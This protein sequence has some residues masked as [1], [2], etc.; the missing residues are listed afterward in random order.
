MKIVLSLMLTGIALLATQSHSATFFADNFEASGAAGA[1]RL[2]AP[3]QMNKEVFTSTGAYVGGYYPG[4]TFGPNS[5]VTNQGGL[6]QG[7]YQGKLHPDFDGFGGDWTENKIVKTSLL[8][9]K[10]LTAAD[11]APGVIQMDFNFKTPNIGASGSVVAFAK[12]LN[13]TFSETW[14]TQTINLNSANWASGATV[15]TFDGTQVGANAQFGFT[16]TSQNYHA[17]DLFIDN[18]TISNVPEPSS[19]TLMGLGVAGLLAFRLR[20]KV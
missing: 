10:T 15:L 18:V 8:F 16:V 14:Y 3:W 1:T 5:I 17:A 4:T 7:D 6:P 13:S 20:R 2:G 12:L 9:N 11:I 19:A